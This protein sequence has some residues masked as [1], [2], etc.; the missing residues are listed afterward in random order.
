[1]SR[2]GYDVVIV[3]GGS[4]GSVLAARLSENRDLTVCLLEAGDYPTDPDIAVP[5]KWPSLQGRSY[6]WDYATAPQ[7]GTAGRVHAW[8]RGRII[9]GSS[10]LHAMAHIRGHPEDFSSWAAASGSR[11]W[12]Y[13]GL[14]PGFIRSESFSGGASRVHGADG[15]MPVYLPD[16]EINPVVRAYMEAGVSLGA[17]RLPDHNSGPLKGVAANSLTIRDGRRVSAADAYLVPVLARPNLTVITNAPVHRLAIFGQRVT[18]V[19]AEIAGQPRTISAARTILSAGAVASPLLLMRSGI[20][21]ARNLQAAGVTCVADCPAV[22]ANLHDHLLI[23]G[24]LYAATRPVPPSRLQHSESL[25]YLDA[26]DPGRRDGAPD[27]ALACVAA[28]T[29]SEC[30]EAPEYGTAYTIL[31]GVSH[32]TSRGHL[33]ISGPDLDHPPVIDPAYLST[34]HDRR[35][36]IRALELARAVG[37]AAPLDDW[38]AAEL[39]PGPANADPAEI[40]EFIERASITHHHPVG[41]CSM[42]TGTEGVVDADL[43]L[44]GFAGAFVVDASVIP[45]ITSGPVNAAV[46]AIAET[47]AADLASLWTSA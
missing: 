31:A 35:L 44:Q 28:P 13:E 42:G 38:R 23:A 27:I 7:P 29:V 19:V 14:L 5:Q 21:P 8:P 46:L 12:S 4:A 41:T 26:D 47:F 43:K 17:P 11:R 45:S 16:D 32:P 6:D 25:M 36:S 18:G 9:G 30:F 15:P 24:N 39:L 40:A 1:M 2:S 3:G 33:T 20:G 10:C 34:E 22:G 37:H